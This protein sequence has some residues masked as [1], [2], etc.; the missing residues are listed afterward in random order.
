MRY[1]DR[2]VVEDIPY[3]AAILDSL[4]SEVAAPV[5]MIIDLTDIKEVGIGL[6]DLKNSAPPNQPKI[7][8]MA[9]VTPNKI[10][11][12]LASAAIQFSSGYYRM[13]STQE[14][15]IAFL[16]AQDPHLKEAFP[17]VT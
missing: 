2:I 8:W 5:H 1:Y 4:L 9:V 11:R 6:R 16:I 12:F 7:H 14:E 17:D 13:F 15:A 10:F 3:G